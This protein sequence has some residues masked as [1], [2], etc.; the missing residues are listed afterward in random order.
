MKVPEGLIDPK[1]YYEGLKDGLDMKENHFYRLF[2]YDLHDILKILEEHEAS[3]KPLT[4]EDYCRDIL[5]PM[6]DKFKNN[7]EEQ[8]VFEIRYPSGTFAYKIWANGRIEGFNN[9][10]T[11]I[12]RIPQYLA[13]HKDD[14]EYPMD[15][16]LTTILNQAVV[17]DVNHVIKAL[18]QAGFTVSKN[19][20]IDR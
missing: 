12:N 5:N 13:S 2:G 6:V 7:K 14:K 10:V 20:K 19:S 8:P 16:G 18:R 3:K 17:C 4:L 9:K 11:V 1:S 15:I